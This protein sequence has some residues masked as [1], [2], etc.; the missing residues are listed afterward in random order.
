[1]LECNVLSVR[2]SQYFDTKKLNT[3][4][5]TTEKGWGVEGPKHFFLYI[6]NFQIKNLC[7][8]LVQEMW[9][10][11]HISSFFFLERFGTSNSIKCG[12]WFILNMWYWNSIT[13]SIFVTTLCGKRNKDKHTFIFLY[14]YFKAD[15]I[16]CWK[17]TY[18]WN[19]SPI[20]CVCVF[21]NVQFEDCEN[22]KKHAWAGFESRGAIM[23]PYAPKGFSY[24]ALP[25]HLYTTSHS[26]NNLAWTWAGSW[27][28]SSLTG[29]LF[30]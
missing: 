15:C 9:L 28:S 3:S 20:G 4:F 18:I 16:T 25:S 1:M 14:F 26:K 7:T 8:V 6:Y 19:S 21:V 22:G 17:T 5:D 24:L 12:Y 13:V 27:T 30:F 23:S 11:Q 29:A 10:N 2:P